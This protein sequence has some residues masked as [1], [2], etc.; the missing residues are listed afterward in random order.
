MRSITSNESR[1]HYSFL[2]SF[3]AT[4]IKGRRLL[5][6]LKTDF[7]FNRLRKAKICLKLGLL[8]KNFRKIT[9]EDGKLSVQMSKFSS[10]IRKQKN[11]G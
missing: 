7:T 3:S 9:L 6:V 8:G 4:I 10:T 5:E 11:Q 1:N 2:I